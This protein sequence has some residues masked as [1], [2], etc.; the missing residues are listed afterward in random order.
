MEAVVN[1]VMNIRVWLLEGNLSTILLKSVH[2]QHLT[3]FCYS[4]TFTSLS[5]GVFAWALVQILHKI[6]HSACACCMFASSYPLFNHIKCVR[7]SGRV[8][9]PR[10]FVLTLRL[11]TSALCNTLILLRRHVSG[12]MLP[13]SDIHGSVSWRRED[14]GTE[15]RYVVKIVIRSWCNCRPVHYARKCFS[16]K[17][18]LKGCILCTLCFRQPLSPCPVSSNIKTCTE[19]FM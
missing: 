3:H 18:F 15:T 13:S 11:P 2:M 16:V 10:Q 19:A 12:C 4:V 8:M 6:S 14:G 5:H 9:K 1:T 7:W 17:L